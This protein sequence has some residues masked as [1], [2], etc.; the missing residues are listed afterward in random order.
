M[1]AIVHVFDDSGGWE[2]RVAASQLLDRLPSDRFPQSLA[3]IHPIPDTLRRG[4]DRPIVLCAARIGLTF[5]AAPALRTFQEKRHAEVIHAWG[6]RAAIA[7]VAAGAKLLVVELFDPG[8]AV[9][10]VKQLRTLARARNFAVVCSCEIVRRRL[11]E[12]GLP[13]DATVVI[14]PGVDLGR[15]NA[16]RRGGLRESLGLRPDQHVVLSNAPLHRDGGQFDTASA[17][18]LLSHFQTNLALILPSEF[19]ERGANAGR[20]QREKDRI[21]RFVRSMPQRPALVTPPDTVPY[22]ELVA[23]S[24]TLVAAPRGDAPTTAIA[25]AMGAKTAV[26]G[27][28]VHCVAELIANKVNGRLFKQTPG[29]SMATT[30]ARLL[31]DRSSYNALTEAAHGQAYEI[32]SVRRYVDQHVRLYENLR[33]GVTPAEGIVD[34]SRVA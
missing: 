16:A 21:I 22:E 7:A 27:S 5:T 3:A 12:G 15:I 10:G 14:R 31:R 23:A 32:F 13:P 34:S 25:W 11:I 24:D 30:I 33:N 19:C 20:D 18:T 29:K 2:Q 17:L 9:R 4:L 26:L 6:V 28:A 8:E 1:P